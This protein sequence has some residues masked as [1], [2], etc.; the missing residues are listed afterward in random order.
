MSSLQN[1]FTG[2]HK[3]SFSANASGCVDVGRGTDGRTY[4][5]RDTKL[6]ANSPVVKA[7]TEAWASFYQ[8]VKSGEFDLT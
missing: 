3:S 6:G 7:T 5:I 8:A 2:W 1:K 4:G